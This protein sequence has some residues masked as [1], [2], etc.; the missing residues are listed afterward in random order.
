MHT[1]SKIKNNLYP[2]DRIN[3]RLTH[4][5]HSLHWRCNLPERNRF[6]TTREHVFFEQIFVPPSVSSPRDL[7][8]RCP[9]NVFMSFR[10]FASSLLRSVD[11]FSCCMRVFALSIRVCS[12]SI[13]IQWTSETTARCPVRSSRQ[14]STSRPGLMRQFTLTTV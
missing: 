4:A 5:V 8:E 6:V 10:M 1:K 11:V 7:L 14:T 2:F 3:H 13:R 12:C 9:T